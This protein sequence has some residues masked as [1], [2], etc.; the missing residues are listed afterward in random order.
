[1]EE[2]IINE[3]WGKLRK[4]DIKEREVHLLPFSPGAD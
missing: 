1:M 4:F 2:K 3:K